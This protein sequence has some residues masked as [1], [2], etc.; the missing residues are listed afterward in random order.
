[1]MQR[2]FGMTLSISKEDFISFK[3]QSGVFT[4]EKASHSL[5]FL[6][7]NKTTFEN[8][9]KDTRLISKQSLPDSDP[10]DYPIIGACDEIMKN[11]SQGKPCKHGKLIQTRIF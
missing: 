9:L 3:H 6:L 11:L 5:Y 4:D 10:D 8:A 7:S 2:V 1:M